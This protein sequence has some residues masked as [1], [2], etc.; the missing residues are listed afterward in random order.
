MD[1]L[2]D[3]LDTIELQRHKRL[4]YVY[5]VVL[6]IASLLMAVPLVWSTYQVLTDPI[7]NP[8]HP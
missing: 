4:E 8:E 2:S 1:N 6:V 5:A 7:E 3:I